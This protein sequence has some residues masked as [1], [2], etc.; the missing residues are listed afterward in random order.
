MPLCGI[1]IPPEKNVR[2]QWIIK[3]HHL[4]ETF[5]IRTIPK[6]YLFLLLVCDSSLPFSERGFKGVACL[7]HLLFSL[8]QIFPT[9]AGQLSGR[10][11]FV[12]VEV[13]R[14]SQPNGVMSSA[15]S[16]PNHVYWVSLVI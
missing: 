12:C 6:K 13:L 10:L 1:F 9:D 11:F 8:R 14:P 15:V 3:Y 2:Y 4:S 5:S 7:Y 16:L